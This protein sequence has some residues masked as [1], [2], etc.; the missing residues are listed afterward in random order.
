MRKLALSFLA[1]LAFVAGAQAQSVTWPPPAGT[2]GI[3]CV[4][5]SVSP[6]ILSGLPAF[7]QCDNSG[8]LKFTNGSAGTFGAPST[9]V[10]S[11]QTL[12]PCS[13]AAKLSA[14]INI[15][16]ATTTAIVAPVGPASV[17]V[18]GFVVSIAPSAVTAD[19][20][21][22][23]SGSGVA[24]A[25]TIVALTGTFGNGD[26]TTSAPPLPISYGGAGATVF[27]SPSGYGICALT[28]GTAVNVQGVLT[29][30]QQ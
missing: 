10:T 5:N 30:V 1:L 12:D 19:T 13:Y 16:T 21:L 17:F 8:Q 9:S 28:A 7:I 14:V 24:C 27:R 6:T 3:L 4:Y 2:E 22:F 23:E 20:L 11:V 29:Y 15:T 25:A 18:C 26:L